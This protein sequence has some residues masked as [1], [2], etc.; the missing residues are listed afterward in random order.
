MSKK[1]FAPDIL[2]T[3]AETYRE[4]N[5]TYGDSFLQFG[6][7]MDAL[8]PGGV[9]IEGAHQWNRFGIIVQIVSK[10]TRYASKPDKGHIDSI[11]D[12]MVYAAMLETL[13]T[14]QEESVTEALKL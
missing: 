3:G 12:I 2:D 7:V 14:P 8:Y 10:L 11:H 4:R 9:R 13:D 6:H 5:A 1:P